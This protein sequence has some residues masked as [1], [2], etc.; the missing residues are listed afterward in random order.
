MGDPGEM[1]YQGDKVRLPSHKRDFKKIT[2]ADH[3]N[4]T[5]MELL[6]PAIY[7]K[8]IRHFIPTLIGQDF[9]SLV[10]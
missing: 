8:I 3:V 1:G 2:D 7:K 5:C 4:I 6:L 9:I 10:K